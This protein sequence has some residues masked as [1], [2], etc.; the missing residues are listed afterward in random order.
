M[1]SNPIP[2]H[3]YDSILTSASW[4]W[5]CNVI[6]QC[7]GWIIAQMTKRTN[8]RY[9]MSFPAMWSVFI[10]IHFDVSFKRLR[11]IYL[12]C[13]VE[14]DDKVIVL[15]VNH[16]WQLG[17]V[18]RWVSSRVDTYLGLICSARL[19]HLTHAQILDHYTNWYT[20][21]WNIKTFRPSLVLVI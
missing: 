1:F 10:D 16:Y 8:E 12:I 14:N 9:G 3:W 18:H 7:L 17:A 15:L 5:S 20:L 21:Y 4:C 2:H 13:G 6:L 11:I 19:Q